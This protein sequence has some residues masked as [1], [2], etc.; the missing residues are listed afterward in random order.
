MEVNFVDEYLFHT[1]QVSLTCRKIFLHGAEDFTSSLKAVLLRIFI[2]FKK[3]PSVRFKH[4]N[5]GSNN[6]D[7][8]H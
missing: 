1:P 5:L 6:K 4:D 7:A 8:N 2:A 3:S